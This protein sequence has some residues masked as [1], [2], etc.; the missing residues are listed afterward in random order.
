MKNILIFG[1]FSTRDW[2]LLRQRQQTI[3]EFLTEDFNVFYIERVC[4]RISTKSVGI[5]KTLKEFIGRF[6]LIKNVEKKSRFTMKHL[7]FIRLKIFPFQTGIFRHLNARLALLQI[8]IVMKKYEINHFDTIIIS[9]PANYVNDIFDK[10]PAKNRIYDC[11]QRFEFSKYFPAEVS[12]NDRN[13][14]EKVDLVIADSITIFNEKKEVNKNVVRIPQGIDLKNYN[15][16][17][18]TDVGIPGDLAEVGKPRICYIGSFH[19]SFNFDLIRKLAMDIPSAAIVLIGNETTEAKKKLHRNNIVF[20]GWK[21]YTLL[22][23]YM[24]HMDL[25]VIPYLLSD[26][27][28]GVFPTKLFEYLYFKKPVVATALPDILEYEEYLY[29]ARSEDEFIKFTHDSLFKGKNKLSL[30][31]ED[32]F[33]RF[34]KENSWESRY[35]EFKKYL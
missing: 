22:P 2:H 3:V 26:H 35:K 13:I 12:F 20:L 25:F 24:R 18:K 31:P 30:L 28:K 1:S 8:K 34:L 6:F 14:A 29:V 9:R 19:Q 4:E 5:I 23:I 17:R 10:I 7:Y 33:K 11:V 32:K 16:N 21:H 15:N 27:G